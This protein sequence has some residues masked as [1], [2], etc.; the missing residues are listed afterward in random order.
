MA[1]SV[2]ADMVRSKGMEDCFE[3]DS[4]AT[5]REEI[6]NGLTLKGEYAHIRSVSLAMSSAQISENVS[7]NFTLGAGYKI[8]D[9]NTKIGLPGGKQK[10]VKHDLNMKLDITHK[11][12]MALLRK[13]NDAFSQATSGNS[14]WTFKFSADYQ[15]S[16]A[17][18]FKLYYDRQVNTPLISTS[19]PTVNSDFGMTLSFS[20]TR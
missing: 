19:Y 4:A 10:D 14:A 2:F 11:S 5:S 18:Q 9:F 8:A 6:G 15:F 3:I 12:Q 20:L 13:I 16:K 17:L 7:K 1:Q